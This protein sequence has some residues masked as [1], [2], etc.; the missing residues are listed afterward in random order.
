M[1]GIEGLK[2]GGFPGGLGN[3]LNLNKINVAPPIKI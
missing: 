1:T 3:G 2:L